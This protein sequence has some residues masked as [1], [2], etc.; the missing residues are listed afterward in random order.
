[1]SPYTELVTRFALQN[2]LT[3]CDVLYPPA[4]RHTYRSDTLQ[5]SSA[6]DFMLTSNSSLTVDFKI[7]DIDCNLSDHLPIIATVICKQLNDVSK[8]VWRPVTTY[9]RW[10]RANL[11][12]YYEQTRVALE[13][14]LYDITSIYNVR[15]CME[16]NDIVEQI[17]R[18]YRQ[19]VTALVTCAD[20]VIPRLKQNFFKFWWSEELKTLKEQSIASSRAWKDA[21]KP[22]SGEIFLAYKRDKIL[23]K[24][25]IKEEKSRETSEFTNDLHDA[26]EA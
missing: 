22:K 12:A 15:D 23:Y 16:V 9:L 17:D 5:C 3:R 7:L 10:D 8:P 19:I 20:L 18:I 2:G 6:I 21:G 26:L 24:R 13:P 1:M 4:C 25:C 11:R 14:M